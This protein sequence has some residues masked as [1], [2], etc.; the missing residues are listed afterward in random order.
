MVDLKDFYGSLSRTPH[1][2]QR[3][4]HTSQQSGYACGI[5]AV[6]IVNNLNYF[7]ADRPSVLE[8][9]TSPE[10]VSIIRLADQC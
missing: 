5:P 8:W 2:I 7:I 9:R 6:F 3:A 4:T 1:L 10:L